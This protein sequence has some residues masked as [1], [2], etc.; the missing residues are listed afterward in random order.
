[1]R[2]PARRRRWLLAKALETNALVD[3]LALAQAVE[4][5]I[6]GKAERYGDDPASGVVP[7]SIFEVQPDPEGRRKKMPITSSVQNDQPTMM[8]AAL[9]GLTS[10]A[11]LDDVILYLRQ[12]DE[13]VLSESENADEL[14]ARA[15][16]MRQVQGLP[17][18]ALLP[19]HLSE[20]A[21]QDKID[22]VEKVRPLRPPS[23]RERAE[24]AR[25]VIALPAK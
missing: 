21:R 6:S 1:M 10:L 11:S 18:F 7:T 23:A 3:A 14:L 8:A 13:A 20:S 15:N 9:V 25:G 2:D 19:T 4:E 24:W 12:N 5:F 17:P 22:R 16:L